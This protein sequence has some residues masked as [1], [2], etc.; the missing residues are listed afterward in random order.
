[1][2][3]RT[4]AAFLCVFIVTGLFAGGCA[5]SHDPAAAVPGSGSV[6]PAGNVADGGYDLISYHSI[7]SAVKGVPQLSFVHL[8]ATYLFSSEE[9]RDAFLK[10]PQKYLPGFGS[11]CPVSLSKG[12]NEKGKP[13][14]WRI[15]KG[16]LYFFSSEDA[17]KE[18]D[19]DPEPTLK[20]ASARELPQGRD[21]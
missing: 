14:I 20:K 6:P 5:V 13:T 1:M 9:N 8:G 7:G 18:F 12:R 10:A 3:S 19:R 4:I 2:R 16:K 17:A 21:Q 15:H 11:H